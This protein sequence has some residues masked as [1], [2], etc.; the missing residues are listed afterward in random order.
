M[1]ALTSPRGYTSISC[2]F[3]A[4]HFVWWNSLT[5]VW[6][7]V[8]FR[9]IS[10]FCQKNARAI[11]M[12]NCTTQMTPLLKTATNGN[13]CS[14]FLQYFFICYAMILTVVHLCLQCLQGAPLALQPVV[15]CWCVRGNRWPTL[16]DVRWSLLLFPRWLPVCVGEGEER[17]V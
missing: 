10:V 17:C 5:F 4:F 2:H 9:V 11:I 3:T 14:I 6:L 13:W 8:Y 12:D 16:R 15:L 1:F 7:S